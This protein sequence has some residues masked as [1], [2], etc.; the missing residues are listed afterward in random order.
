MLGSNFCFSL[1]EPA[2]VRSDIRPDDFPEVFTRR[3]E[4]FKGENI[5]VV[6]RESDNEIILRAFNNGDFVFGYED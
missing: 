1:F 3:G 2:V 5:T 6:F 4:E